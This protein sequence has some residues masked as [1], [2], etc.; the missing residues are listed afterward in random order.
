MEETSKTTPVKDGW[1]K[2]DA[3]TG[4]IV[5]VRTSKGVAK[6]S[7]KTRVVVKG[8]SSKRSAALKRLANR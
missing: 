7:S 1:V 3:R 5:E 4:R 6:A 8:A 2:R